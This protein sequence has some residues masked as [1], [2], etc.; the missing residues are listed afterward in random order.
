M[1]EGYF[2]KGLTLLLLFAVLSFNFPQIFSSSATKLPNVK[3][4]IDRTREDG[5][6]PLPSSREYPPSLPRLK[7][8]P[9]KQCSP[10]PPHTPKDIHD[11]QPNDINVVMAIGDSITAAFGVMGR[12]G[13]LDEFRGQSA[14]IGG[15]P[16]A[17]TAAAFLRWF[18]PN[19][20]GLAV[21]YHFLETPGDAWYPD[22]DVLDGA[23]SGATAEQLIPQVRYIAS[24]AVQ[25]P[26]ID[27][28]ND[29]KVLSMLVGAND[30]CGLCSDDPRPSVHHA[31]KQ[32]EKHIKRVFQEIYDTIPRVFV[33]VVPMFN[34]SHL[35]NLTKNSSY[36][37][38]LHWAFLECDC[39]YSEDPADRVY[40]D[41]VLA[42]YREVTFKAVDDWYAEK[43]NLTDF[44]LVIQPFSVGLIL[45]DITYLSD[46]DCFHPSLLAHQKVAIAGWN[47]MITPAA[48]KKRYFEPSDPI[49]CPDKDTK[50]YTW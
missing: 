30:V 14:P 23:Q 45:P 19:V 11:L 5:Q 48:K 36:C 42:Q 15:D 34:M 3:I 44:A 32:Y 27:Y 29:W 47:N 6:K 18:N 12:E 24:Q 7:E 37:S 43:G 1:K 10:L 33:N 2:P 9:I 20:Q 40:L 46:L 49:L 31:G 22:I 39:L 28:L 50:L 41:E 17:I 38:D 13:W 8:N 16:D 35:Y 26:Q 21:G 4:P 25:N